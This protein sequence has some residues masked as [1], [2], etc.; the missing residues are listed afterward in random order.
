MAH[1][2][3]AAVQKKKVPQKH[4]RCADMSIKQTGR[5]PADAG[6]SKLTEQPEHNPSGRSRFSLYENNQI[7]F[8]F[9]MRV[10]R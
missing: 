7:S 2:A 6:K 1:A 4:A 8:V 3:V 5:A 9:W 10:R